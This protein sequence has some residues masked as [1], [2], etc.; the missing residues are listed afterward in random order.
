MSI[1]ILRPGATFTTFEFYNV[2]LKD[3]ALFYKNGYKDI[4]FSLTGTEDLA[5]SKFRIDGNSLP[6]LL[7]IFEQLSVF[8]KKSLLF[9]IDNVRGH[10]KFLG[11]DAVIDFLKNSNFFEIAMRLGNNYERL[12]PKLPILEIPNL[13]DLATHSQNNSYEIDCFSLD[14]DLDLKSKIFNKNEEEK[15][16]ILVEYYM[17]KVEDRFSKLYNKI[18]DNRSFL[19]NS[20]NILDYK[21]FY[22]HILPELI[23]NGVLHSGANTFASLFNDGFKTKISVSDNGVGLQKSMESK[24]NFGFYMPRKL[25]SKLA[26][27]EKFNINQNFLSTLH[28]IFETLY[29]SMLK[30]R[31]GLFDLIGNV[32]LKLDGVFRMHTENTQIILSKRIY[33]ILVKLYGKRKEIIRQHDDF[34]LEKISKEELD[35]NMK[36]LSEDALGLFVDFYTNVISNYSKDVKFSSV[37]FYPVKFK[38][39]HIEVEIPN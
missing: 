36:K 3:V 18:E 11:T 13:K 17:F 37:R 29:F 23:T 5:Y 34:L 35:E 16:D 4:S 12:F 22:L 33:D 25:T 9:K 32:V 1:T 7:N 39:V 19:Q 31:L 8:E 28:L 24:S 30:N 6:L 20:T 10:D 27:V 2:F 15:R 21:K 14:L 38:G 26:E